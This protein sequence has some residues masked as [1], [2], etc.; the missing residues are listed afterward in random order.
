MISLQIILLIMA[1][2]F[3]GDFVL[4]SH[5]MALNKS[6]NNEALWIHCLV[7]C[8]FLWIMTLSPVWAFL[9][10]FLH[11]GVD[12]ITSRIN[13]K[14]WQKGDVHYFFVG[15]G[16]DQLIHYICLFGT[17]VWFVNLGCF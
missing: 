12:Y 10:L 16:A 13:A 3:I 4:Q 2:H 17:F 15:V 11:F 7:Y 5:W 1:I 14:L 8:A 9:N 6:R